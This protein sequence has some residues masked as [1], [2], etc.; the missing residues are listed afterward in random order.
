MKISLNWL[1]EYVDFDLSKI[2]IEELTHKLAVLGFEA[3][4]VEKISRT[5]DKIV[6]G[7]V[8]AKSQHPNADKLSI[9]SVDVGDIETGNLQIVCGAPNV[10]AGQT[11]PVA[12]IG[13]IV[14]DTKMKKSK[15]RGEESFGMICAED[16][17]GLSDNHEGIMVLDDSYSAGT[18][19]KELYGYE[20]YIFDIEVTPN[21]PDVM[22]HLGFAREFAFIINKHFFQSQEA[23]VLTPY[24]VIDDK[25]SDDIEKYI[26]IEI[27]DESACP[28]YTARMIKNVTIKESPDWLKEKLIAVGLRPINNIVDITNFI[29][30]ETGHPMHAFDYSEVKGNKIIV[31]KAEKDEKFVTLDDAEYKLNEEI[32]LI[33]DAEKPVALAGVMGGKNSG[34]EDTTTDVLLEVAYFN[35]ADIRHAVKHLSIFTDSSKRFERGVD[36]NDAQFV[37]DRAA[38]L[39]QELAGG[40]IVAGTKDVYP[41]KISEKAIK[42]RVTRANEILGFE[43]SK[44]QMIDDLNE[45]SLLA[46]ANKKD[47]NKID[48]VIPTFRPDIEK[49][50][51]LIEEVVRLYGFENIPEKSRSTIDLE[52][53]EDRLDV[54][55]DKIRK[56][57]NNLGLYELTSRRMVD[58]KY[59]NA[60]V[61]ENRKTVSIE[62]PLNE[63]MNHLRNSLIISLI[64]NAGNNIR[65]GIDKI[66]IFETGKVF[67]TTDGEEGK[68]RDSVVS[69]DTNFAILLSG[70]KQSVKWNNPEIKYDFYD[71]KGIV[72]TLFANRNINNITFKNEDIPSYY[73]KSEALSIYDT[74]NGKYY[75]SFGKISS[76]VAEIFEVS[77]NLYCFEMKLNDF[78]ELENSANFKLAKLSKYPKV[79]K[80][81]SFEMDKSFESSKIVDVIYKYGK[82]KL[83]NVEVID[84]YEGKQLDSD[85][86]SYSF[87]MTFQSMDKTMSEK[88]IDKLFNKVIYG[89]TKELDVKLR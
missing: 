15:I 79:I 67:Y 83:V 87:R 54:E 47:D 12:R 85:K 46:T 31:R 20:D 56:D 80:D 10:D 45:I 14:G 11:V 43:I 48:V 70:V 77:E 66:N 55:N 8:L 71:I 73:T 6:I 58:E 33:C 42:L 41:T 81:L 19:L 24:A 4:S 86:K 37:I 25:D 9:C 21:R 40:E 50:I 68:N 44:E 23:Q 36:P 61:V 64:R 18:P 53:V 27:K 1:K 3:E 51:D 59:C 28:R 78:I 13:A 57:L 22:G 34:V 88:E 69:E 52:I 7:K 89:V 16:E 74:Y 30:M 82:A 35:L 84:H 76:D 17:L 2:K 60:F 49:E 63:E 26:D 29:V 75:G 62:H 32:L 5:F 72:E 39:M 38:L 65:K